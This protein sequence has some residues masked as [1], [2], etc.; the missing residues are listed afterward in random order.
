MNAATKLQDIARDLEEIDSF[1]QTCIRVSGA[2]R[3][4]QS[5]SSA[6]ESWRCRTQTIPYDVN[7][8][9]VRAAKDDE[10][11][12]GFALELQNEADRLRSILNLLNNNA[13]IPPEE[14]AAYVEEVQ[15]AIRYVVEQEQLRSSPLVYEAL[16]QQ[17]LYGIDQDVR[18][19]AWHHICKMVA[20]DRQALEAAINTPP[21]NRWEVKEL[22][23]LR[24]ESLSARSTLGPRGS[25]LTPAEP[26]AGMAEQTSNLLRAL[27]S[28]ATVERNEIALTLGEFGDGEVAKFLA[29]ALRS[30][31]DA[32]GAD[33]DYQVY[34][35]SALSNIGGPD[36]VEGLL[37]AV[38]TGAQ[39]VRLVALSGLESLATAGAVALT[40]YPEP[41][42][43]E[44]EEMR[45][46]CHN[47]ADRLGTL[48]DVPNT[49]SYVR[50]KA[51]ELLDTILIS[52][53]S[54]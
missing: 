8:E 9:A 14:K 50:H 6:I 44:S 19:L 5:S 39:R 54:N 23:R 1:T 3:W 43:I 32:G 25:L 21:M 10:D 26:A 11:L 15:A 17:A 28:P 22:R 48:I 18:R 33:E 4:V 45:N 24:E 38:E 34:L 47:L 13:T 42:T 51:G 20:Q 2:V 30:E 7:R 27:A 16:V 31:I 36:A 35:A 37:R 29:D 46:A 49:P 12:S 53:N 41:V 40:E 52:L